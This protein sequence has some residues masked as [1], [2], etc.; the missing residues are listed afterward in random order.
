MRRL[1]PSPCSFSSQPPAAACP[2]P[3]SATR[4]SQRLLSR[5]APPVSPRRP[6]VPSQS[7]LSGCRGARPG[8]NASRR[9]ALVA[10][11]IPA[12]ASR[13]AA[14][15]VTGPSCFPP[16]SAAA[17]RGLGR[18]SPVTPCKTPP[19]SRKASP[20]APAIPAARLG[21]RRPRQVLKAAATQAAPGIVTSLLNRIEA[22]R[23]Q[24]DPNSPGQPPRPRL[25][26]RRHRRPRRRQPQP[27]HEPN[28]HQAR[29]PTAWSS[30]TPPPGR[31]LPGKRRRPDR[32][33]R[34]GTV[35]VELQWIVV[36]CQAANAAA[37]CRSTRFPPATINPYWGDVAV[38][39]A[40]KP[41]AAWRDNDVVTER[42]IRTRRP[43]PATN[44]TGGLPL[45]TCRSL[46]TFRQT[47]N[48][49]SDP[50]CAPAPPPAAAGPSAPARRPQP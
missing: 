48:A 13:S 31:R 40:P 6:L 37:S 50:R 2:S 49:P 9:T 28:A 5:P 20:K 17:A 44:P 42:R 11:E 18:S 21:Q 30:R 12:A 1:L 14:A 4:A 38:A 46:P 35:R 45:A 22:A 29:D 39:V 27:R 43:E 32:P 3:S 47:P 34:N 24:S 33:R 15:A 25:P 16:S 23:R 19:A 7:L 36:D 8:L 41:P 10:Q 26:G